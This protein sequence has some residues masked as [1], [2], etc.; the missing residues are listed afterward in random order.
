LVRED[1]GLD[2]L[3]LQET[4]LITANPTPT[5]SGYSAIR[6][7]QPRVP[8]GRR[9]GSGLLTYVKVDIPFC[10]IPA[11][12]EEEVVRG[13]EVLAVEIQRGARGKFV[14]TN[15]Y[16]PPIR[17]GGQGGFNPGAIRV[18]A[19][20]VLLGGDFNAHSSLWDDSQ[21]RD[22]FET[23]LEEWI[24]DNDLIPLND[25]S[26]TRINSSTTGESAPDVTV[27]HNSLVEGA[28]WKQL[29]ARGLDYYPLLWE[30]DV[31]YSHLAELDS[32][33]KWDWGNADWE[34]F[35]KNKLSATS[36]LA[37]CGGL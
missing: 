37:T 6:R 29:P 28:T 5:L 15:L 27:V 1:P 33:L 21:P 35:Q 30:V 9:G 34:N 8:G 10:Q 11:Y 20:Q 32:K 12:S 17:E 18:P 26:R 22:G 4:K 25:G 19:A 16:M 2:V 3:L 31:T 7:D 24:M 13:L 23:I 36:D 14:I